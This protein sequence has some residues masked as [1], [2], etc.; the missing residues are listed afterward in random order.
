M[1]PRARY[2][3]TLIELLIVMMIGS[4]LV[5]FVAPRV[6]TS[7]VAAN[8]TAAI[9]TLRAIHTAQTGLVTQGAQDADAD[10]RTEYAFLAELAGEAPLRVYDSDGGRAVIG[11]HDLDTLSP[12][13]LPGT[14]GDVAAG[15][16]V[17][18]GYVFQVWLPNDDGVGI[19]EGRQ[20][21]SNPDELPDPD[22]CEL[23]WCAYAWPLR[24]GATGNRVFFINQD[25]TIWQMKN[26]GIP[27]GTPE[28]SAAY[29][30]PNMASGQDAGRDGVDSN[31]WTPVH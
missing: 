17:R 2:G 11:R 1:A 28:F 4:I 10:G 6:L 13:L 5:L 7:R 19:S 25:G 30:L 3:F 16:V 27:N 26:I 9:A 18:S 20:G 21:G 12:S 15:A 24:A 23:Y 22:Q 8:E 14:F 31:R 29:A